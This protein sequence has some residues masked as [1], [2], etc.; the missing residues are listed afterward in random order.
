MNTAAV[1]SE[2]APAVERENAGGGAAVSF[3]WWGSVVLIGFAPLFRAA[4]RPLPLMLLEL[5]AIAVLAALCWD[6]QALLRMPRSIVWG[7]GLLALVPVVFLIPVPF[8]VWSALPGRELYGEVLDT[9]WG[10][11]ALPGSRALSVVPWHSLESALALLPP[12]AVF[13]AVQRMPMNRAMRLVA[14]LLGVA[15]LEA[16]LGLAQYGRG[17]GSG[18]LLGISTGHDAVGTY[19][20][21]N[22]LAG[23][24]EMV[25]PIALGLTAATLRRHKSRRSVWRERLAFA[26]T[27]RGHQAMA[28]GLLSILLITGLV[29]TRSRMG[30]GL[31]I[32]GI[33]LSVLAYSRRLGGSNSYGP[34]GSIVA[35]AAGLSAAIGLIPVWQRFGLTDA[36]EDLRWRIFATTLE[37]IGQFF[38]L[39]SGPGT[40]VEVFRRFQPSGLAPGMY[41]NHAH[42]DYLEWLL[43]GGLLAALVMVWAL[44]VYARHWPRIWQKGAWPR[45]RFVQVGAGLG[46]LLL[47]LHGLVDYNL[48]IPA[49]MVFFALLMGVFLRPPEE[50]T[51]ERRHHRRRHRHHAARQPTAVEGPV[52]VQQAGEDAKPAWNPFMDKEL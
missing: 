14:L 35:A 19:A 3:A 8:S 7:I 52:P 48:R 1:L 46:V 34:L 26:S 23:L 32:L 13:L 18:L 17:A 27:L 37:A 6:R 30:I 22:H 15:A 25:L 41:V 51:A 10:T 12:L 29:F 5:G 42:N 4:N 28:F 43:E 36:V 47:L 16:A 2:P 20:N 44:V 39:G 31:G 33:V 24:L 38:P 45:S 49:N 50:Y 9:A 21:R 11:L 40:F